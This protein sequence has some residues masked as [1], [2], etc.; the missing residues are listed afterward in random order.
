MPS[1]CKA[2][3]NNAASVDVV[4]GEIR[5]LTRERNSLNEDE[6][7]E[8]EEEEDNNRPDPE[9]IEEEALEVVDDDDNLLTIF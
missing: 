9:G 7:E 6:E 2:A 8:E 3:E 5:N 4:A 1:C